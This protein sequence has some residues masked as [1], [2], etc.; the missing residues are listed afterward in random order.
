MRSLDEHII[1]NCD[2]EMSR[3]PKKRRHAGRSAL[4]K[5]SNFLHRESGMMVGVVHVAI[6][7]GG[8]AVDGE[9][10][11]AGGVVAVAGVTVLGWGAGGAQLSATIVVRCAALQ[12]LKSSSWHWCR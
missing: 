9:A 11:V 10:S 2:I 1:S 5:S 12:A 6:G 7:D 3:E 8:E 4:D